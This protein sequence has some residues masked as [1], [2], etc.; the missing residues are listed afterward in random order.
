MKMYYAT[1]QY[2]K[3][4]AIAESLLAKDPANKEAI[5]NLASCYNELARAENDPVK[6][7]AL[8]T[9]AS[10]LLCQ[11]NR[12]SSQLSGSPLQHGSSVRSDGK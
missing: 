7:A 3:S 2:E 11:R 9:K 8:Q 1:Q 10:G 12:E 5:S 6:K 4:L